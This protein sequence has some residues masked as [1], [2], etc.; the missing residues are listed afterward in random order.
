[1][2]YATMTRENAHQQFNTVLLTVNS[3]TGKA[4]FGE[5]IELVHPESGLRQKNWVPLEYHRKVY[6]IQRINPLVVVR[7]NDNDTTPAV[8][9]AKTVYTQDKVQ[10]PFPVWDPIDSIIIFMYVYRYVF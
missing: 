9:E 1:M 5:N 8:R 2:T 3:S 7:P 6:Y 4:Q 10:L